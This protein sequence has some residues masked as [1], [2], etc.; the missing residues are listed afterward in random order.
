VP[1]SRPPSLGLLTI[2]KNEAQNLP[3]S[4]EPLVKVVGEAVF[5]DT[6]STDGS[7]SLAA[8]MGARVYSFPWVNDF[9]LARNFALSQMTADYVFWL[10][11]DNA[12]DPLALAAFKKTL[13]E[14]P[15]VYLALERVI[16]QGDEIWQTRIF[17][18]LPPAHWEGQIHEQLICPPSW[19]RVVS[20]LIVDHWGYADPRLAQKKG[21]RNLALLLKTPLNQANPYHLYQTGRTLYYLRRRLEARPWLEEAANK[22]ENPALFSHSLILLGSV[23][24]TLGDHKAALAAF[25]RLTASRPDYGPGHYFLG[26]YL[27]LTDPARALKELELALAYG[28][29]DPGWGANGPK[30]SFIASLTLGKL[31]FKA[32]DYPLAEKHLTAALNLDPANPEPALELARLALAKGE[33]KVAKATLTAVL[34]RFP[35]LRGALV[36]AKELNL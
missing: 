33:K 29:A 13:S 26:R 6:G 10:D 8:A 21:E 4:L 22:A 7:Q 16:P 36:L 17:P 9:S 35:N 32:K 25:E 30:L 11:G 28:L 5:V 24:Q 23:Y 3:K 34:S 19:P 12:V 2:A 31:R 18:N 14:K 20:S 15:T 1:F 27:T